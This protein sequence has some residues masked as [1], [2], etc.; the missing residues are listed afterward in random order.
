MSFGTIGDLN[1]L[2][3]IVGAIV[4]FAIGAVWFTPM[5][6]GRPWQRAMGWDPNQTPPQMSAALYATPAV[7]YLLVAIATGML[8]I[9]TGSDTFG[10]GIV[11]GL[12]AG[13]GYAA[14]ILAVTASFDPGKPQPWVWFSITAAYHVLGILVVAVL[15]SV[16]R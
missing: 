3:V 4:Y 9:A 1:W 8:A 2:A 12:V 14:T 5:G 6:F 7:A 10:S 11:L 13:I 16:W 15:V